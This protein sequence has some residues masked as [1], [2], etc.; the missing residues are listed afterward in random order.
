M[1]FGQLGIVTEEL[2][3]QGF[4]WG[5]EFGLRVLATETVEVQKVLQDEDQTAEVPGLQY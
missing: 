1:F 4:S 3:C 5:V 2:A